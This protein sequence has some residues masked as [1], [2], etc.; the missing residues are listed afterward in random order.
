MTF[1]D[2]L[3]FPSGEIFGKSKQ[4]LSKWGLCLKRSNSSKNAPFVAISALPPWLWG[5]EELVP[6]G[7]E[8]APIGPEKARFPRKDSQAILRAK[9]QPRAKNKPQRSPANPLATPPQVPQNPL[10]KG[11][12]RPRT[13]S[14]KGPPE[15]PRAPSR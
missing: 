6:I 11:N 8:K 5:A 15:V 2:V 7:P 13:P 1:S 10:K 3:D 12:S 14:K 9:K 4:G